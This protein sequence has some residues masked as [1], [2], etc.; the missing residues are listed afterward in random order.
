MEKRFSTCVTIKCTQKFHSFVPV[1]TSTSKVVV[2]AFS[3]ASESRIES[4]SA[5]DKLQMPDITG[6]I[7]VVYDQKWWLAYVI[8]KNECDDD[9]KLTFLHPAGPSPSFGFPRRPN[10]LWLRVNDVLCT[11]NP[12][13][14]IGRVYFITTLDEHKTQEAFKVYCNK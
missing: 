6:Y 9:I 14:P 4:V 12:S 3:N 7:T 11:V 10:I 1:V 8:G 5:S 2:K 13:T